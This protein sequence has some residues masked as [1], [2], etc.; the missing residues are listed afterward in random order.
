MRRAVS[1]IWAAVRNLSNQDLIRQIKGKYYITRHRVVAKLPSLDDANALHEPA[2]AY[3]SETSKMC[4]V[5]WYKSHLP[6]TI[7][8]QIWTKDF[9]GA[10]PPIET[11]P[12][13]TI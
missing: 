12:W 1:E 6:L 10:G 9:S 4:Y 7:R 5:S 13:Q 11:A 2:T 3:T 8:P